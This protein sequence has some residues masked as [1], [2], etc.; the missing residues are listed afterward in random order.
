MHII[1]NRANGRGCQV[2]ELR[3]YIAKGLVM[4]LDM[5]INVWMDDPLAQLIKSQEGQPA[6]ANY[7][8][9]R[10]T[11]SSS[12]IVL[13]ILRQVLLG[14]DFS[15]IV[16]PIKAMVTPEFMESIK[17][18]DGLRPRVETGKEFQVKMS[19]DGVVSWSCVGSVNARAAKNQARSRAKQGDKFEVWHGEDIVC[20]GTAPSV[21]HVRWSDIGGHPII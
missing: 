11:L 4:S 18:A 13:C 7:P 3:I 9:N 16:D 21:K 8:I 1:G 14:E 10:E 15:G 2:A 12:G 17:P 20:C 19:R 6:P 5:Q